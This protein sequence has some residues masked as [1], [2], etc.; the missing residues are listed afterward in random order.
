MPPR[1]QDQTWATAWSLEYRLPILIS[2]LLACAVGGL[3]LAAYREVRAT[4]IGRATEV[5]ERVER[6]LAAAGARPNIARVEALRALADDP[7]IVHALAGG[8]STAALEKRFAASRESHDTVFMAWHLASVDGR[9]RYGSASGW[10]A[11]DSAELKTTLA[12]VVRSESDRRS[13]L[14]AVGEHVH[15]WLAVP[16]V[17]DGRVVGTLA[18]LA[19]VADNYG[20]DAVIRALVD[21]DARMLF[22]NRGGKQWVSLRGRPVAAPF[23]L[24][25]VDD[26]AVRV[27]VPGRG[28][29]Y[30]I[31]SLIPTTPWL[32]VLFQSER[33][34]LQKP[35]DFLRRIII[36]GLFV[37]ALATVG[38]WFLGR[39]VT[40]PLREVT[41][42]ASDLALGDYTRRVDVQGGAREVARLASVF[43]AMAAAT[44]DAHAVLAE[45]NAELQ[46]AN[47]A[48]AQFLAMMS[49]E[50]RTPLNAIGGFTELMELGLRGPVT[51]EQ[52]EDLGRIR[53]NKDLLVAIITDILDFSRTDAGALTL[54][55]EPVALAPVL[56]DVADAVRNQ[57][58]A[59]GVRLEIGEV[60]AD[61]VVRGD[62][63]KILQ[64]LLNLLSNAMKFTE[65]GGEVDIHTIVDEDAVRIEVRD[66]GAGISPAQLETIFEPFVQVDASLTRRAGGTGLGLAISRQLTRAMGGTVTVRSQ[67]GAGSTF[68]LTL[69][70]TE[71]LP[72]SHPHQRQTPRETSQVV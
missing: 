23:T 7:L 37:L 40:R 12:G 16:V 66:T 42:A 68:S 69:P 70:R 64:V 32:V 52:V 20:A 2:L 35:H 48:K 31:Q 18:E 59:K 26:R 36:A 62:R 19:R 43:N 63:K 47:A 17:S 4:T 29:V 60:P 45:R 49:H 39:L 13:L 21:D 8:A 22:T 14:Y 61:A 67:L 46:R 30:V 11:I 71:P 57:M 25:T 5:L 65:P 15:G 44:G 51:P 6:E 34:I 10:T 72:V 55:L 58:A 9:Q 28:G 27:D 24:P 38:A 53:R 54:E 3:S 41:N 1:Q 50:L 33:S 56:T